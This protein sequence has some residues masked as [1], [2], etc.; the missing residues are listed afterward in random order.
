MTI[1]VPTTKRKPLTPHQRMKMF[2]DHKGMCIVCKLPI[3]PAKGFIDEHIVPLGLGGTND[4]SNR[5]PAHKV[6]AAQKTLAED[7]PRIIK[8]KAQKAAAMGK[9]PDARPSFPKA[10]KPPK[11]ERE[12]A[13][14]LP[15]IFRRF[16][17][18]Q[19]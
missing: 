18:N 12:K 14:G 8:A 15:E 9:S 5:A 16:G 4:M 17:L 2:E 11:V 1:D 19:H 6:C 13:N 10:A 7:M 3:D